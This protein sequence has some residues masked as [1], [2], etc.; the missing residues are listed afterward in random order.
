MYVE[1]RMYQLYPGK[2]DEYFT[3]YQSHG[4]S[5]QQKYLP[6]MLGY[7]QTEVGPQNKHGGPPVGLRE[8]G[9]ARCLQGE[10]LRRPGLAVLPAEDPAADPANGH[11][12]HEVR[13]LFS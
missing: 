3:H 11:A 5:V 9:P 12:H 7:Y 1:E 13:S 6:H 10:A 2:V 4:M 8:P